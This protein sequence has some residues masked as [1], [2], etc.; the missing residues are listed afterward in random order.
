MIGIGIPL[1]LYFFQDY[2]GQI[3]VGEKYEFMWG[4][5]VTYEMERY[6]DNYR[7]ESIF[8]WA[9]KAIKEYFE[10]RETQT[11]EEKRE[12]YES[13]AFKPDPRNPDPIRLV[14]ELYIP[15]NLPLGFGVI[16]VSIGISMLLFSFSPN[17]IKPRK[18]EK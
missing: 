17:E 1:V 18:E 4:V 13:L 5:H 7:Q 2:P 14:T 16:L 12:Y 8:K 3:V 9:K 11:E 6:I 10:K 15:Y